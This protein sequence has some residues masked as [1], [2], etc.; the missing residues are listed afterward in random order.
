[1]TRKRKITVA[2]GTAAILA[3]IGYARQHRPRPAF[4]AKWRRSR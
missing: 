4:R 2:A 3:A 1:M